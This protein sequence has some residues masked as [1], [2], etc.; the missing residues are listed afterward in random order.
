MLTRN[1]I[2]TNGRTTVLAEF[3]TPEQVNAANFDGRP[4]VF[5]N[6][7]EAARNQELLGTYAGLVSSFL[8]SGASAVVTQHV[9]RRRCRRR[10][11]GPHVLPGRPAVQR[12]RGTGGGALRRERPPDPPNLEDV[13]AATVALLAYQ[14]Y[15]HPALRLRHVV[16]GSPTE[17]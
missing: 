13:D 15:G 9:D 2:D 4:F 8:K 3:L 14:F 7:C 16:A 17:P 5:L 1:N 11:S 10:R 12:R 6:A